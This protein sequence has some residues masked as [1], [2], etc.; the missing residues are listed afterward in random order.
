MLGLQ[1][2]SQAFTVYLTFYYVETLNLAVG[3]AA[4]GRAIFSIWDAVDNILFGYL[5]DNTR[6]KWGRRRPWLMLALPFLFTVF[7]SCVHCT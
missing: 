7:Y 1:I 3:L 2:P 5:S 6:T 4:I